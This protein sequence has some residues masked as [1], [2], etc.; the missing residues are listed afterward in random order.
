MKRTY[1]L[2]LLTIVSLSAFTQQISEI[3]KS[4]N[5]MMKQAESYIPDFHRKSVT[6]SYPI[7][8]VLTKK[9]Y[10]KLTF[11]QVPTYNQIDQYLDFDHVE[12]DY[13]LAKTP[14]SIWYLA[15]IYDNYDS[16]YYFKSANNKLFDYLDSIKPDRVYNLFG[17]SYLIL[18]EKNGHRYL[19]KEINKQYRPCE[20]VDIIPDVAF[21]NTWYFPYN[22]KKTL[23]YANGNKT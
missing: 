18:I 4:M 9:E 23:I 17:R 3:D 14:D 15:G 8:N 5:E 16:F 21:F 13:I 1:F 11:S 6:A 10:R 7:F 19:I 12:L 2:I 20:I 22:T